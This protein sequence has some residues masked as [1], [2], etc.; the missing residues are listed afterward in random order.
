MSSFWQ[1]QKNVLMSQRTLAF[2]LGI[3]QSALAHA[4]SG[5]RNFP[6]E[7]AKML[8]LMIEVSKDPPACV[9]NQQ[10][11]TLLKNARDPMTKSLTATISD[12]EIKLEK[13]QAKLVS[14]KKSFELYERT[15]RFFDLLAQHPDMQASDFWMSVIELK[16]MEASFLWIKKREDLQQLLQLEI[17]VLKLNIDGKKEILERM[18]NV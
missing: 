1:L 13:L 7:S 8:R 15:R 12:E 9:L 5:R 14:M 2:M 6:G 16:R 10:E 17:D 11:S 3:D 4:E 18:R